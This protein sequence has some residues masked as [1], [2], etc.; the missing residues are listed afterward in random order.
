M[1]FVS[2]AGIPSGCKALDETQMKMCK[3][4]FRNASD[5]VLPFFL[6][7]LEPGFLMLRLFT[8]LIDDLL[9]GAIDSPNTEMEPESYRGAS[10]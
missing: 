4:T 5:G 8:V 6:F 7:F 3:T 1:W 10:R 9:T 2:Y